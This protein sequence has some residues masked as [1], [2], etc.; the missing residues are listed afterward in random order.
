MPVHNSTVLVSPVCLPW[1]HSTHTATST[2]T[3]PAT[4]TLMPRVDQVS[5]SATWAWARAGCRLTLTG[6]CVAIRTTSA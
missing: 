6:A 4:R 2:P 5:R 3:T 1:Y